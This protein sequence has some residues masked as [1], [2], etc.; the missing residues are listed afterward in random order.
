MNSSIMTSLSILTKAVSNAFFKT[1]PP[2]TQLKKMAV[3]L[4]DAHKHIT[5]S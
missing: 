4:N 2:A 1:V 5:R 3:L